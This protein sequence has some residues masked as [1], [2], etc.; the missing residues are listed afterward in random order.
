[1]KEYRL[2]REEAIS[3]DYDEGKFT[4]PVIDETGQKYDLVVNRDTM[5]H[6]LEIGITMTAASLKGKEN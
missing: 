5:D 4:I 3:W 1:M 6:I 2:D